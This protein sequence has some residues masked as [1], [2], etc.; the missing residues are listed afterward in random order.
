MT[1]VGHVQAATQ[2]VDVLFVMIQT[3]LVITGNV[4]IQDLDLVV[5]PRASNTSRASCQE[6]FFLMTS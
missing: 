2:Y 1:H 3:G 5:S 4:L 6:T